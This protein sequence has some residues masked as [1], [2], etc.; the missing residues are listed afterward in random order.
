MDSRNFATN[1]G[2]L[3]RSAP[4]CDVSNGQAFDTT[5]TTSSADNSPSA[6]DE[7]NLFSLNTGNKGC[8]VCRQK[9]TV[10]C[11]TCGTMY[12]STG[13]MAE[14]WKLHMR[15]CRS[16]C[17]W[18]KWLSAACI[19]RVP[20]RRQL[21]SKCLASKYKQ[22]KISIAHDVASGRA[23]LVN[24]GEQGLA[25]EADYSLRA[26]F[27]LIA[28]E[29][30]SS[31]SSLGN[32]AVALLLAGWNSLAQ[33]NTICL[34]A[35]LASPGIGAFK[36]D[37]R[38]LNTSMWPLTSS[39]LNGNPFVSYVYLTSSK[40]LSVSPRKS[41]AR[42]RASPKKTTIFHHEFLVFRVGDNFML[43]QARKGLYTLEEWLDK[44]RPLSLL[45]ACHS[46][47]ELTTPRWRGEHVKEEWD[48]FVADL[49]SLLSE[50]EHRDAYERITGIRM[51]SLYDKFLISWSTLNLS[52][53]G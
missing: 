2:L 14:A 46:E 49:G 24:V 1:K 25:E 33:S 41:Y 34:S 47:F 30:G 29:T 32:L 15:S 44:G 31:E 10:A 7:Y 53:R 43:A 5:N 4:T 42:V 51:P 16:L 21:I 19:D 17:R 12:C 45:P 40:S 8:I 23:P 39:T 20:A 3:S 27:T 26:L 52:S 35:T 38:S 36:P 37:I 48:D 13:H 9:A 6:E 22:T 50:G 11:A 18:A 28:E